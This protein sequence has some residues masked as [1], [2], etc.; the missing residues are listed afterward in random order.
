MMETLQTANRPARVTLK[1][2]AEHLGLTPGTISAV[3]NNSRAAER[4]PQRTRE[5][6]RVAARELHYQPNVWARALRT[7]M[8]ASADS[9]SRTPTR[10]RAIVILDDADFER[11]INA[12]EEAGLRVP[13]HISVLAFSDSPAL[14]E[15]PSLATAP[16]YP[17]LGAAQV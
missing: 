17:E 12:I 14:W 2:I 6:I 15:H 13:D 10:R 4:I 3:L 7:G 5:R 16:E 11:A 1:T 9:E 8:R